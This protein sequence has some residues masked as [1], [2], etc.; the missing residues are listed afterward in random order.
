MGSK[1]HDLLAVH[2]C[3]EAVRQELFGKP[4]RIWCWMFCTKVD[5][6][7]ERLDGSGNIVRATYEALSVPW[8]EYAWQ[9]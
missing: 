6:L 5:L 2:A 9:S 7:E 1:V 8:E 4:H 3:V